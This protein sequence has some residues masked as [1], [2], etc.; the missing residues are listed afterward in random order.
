MYR[1]S[2]SAA[3]M[4]NCQNFCTNNNLAVSLPS[5]LCVQES[6]GGGG[7]GAHASRQTGRIHEQDV[8]IPRLF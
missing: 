3:V 5:R 7:G 6:G 8:S 1:S 2:G 4:Y